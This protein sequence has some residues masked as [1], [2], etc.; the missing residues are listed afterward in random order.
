ML[1][2][3][4]MAV[5]ARAVSAR[6]RSELT[7]RPFAHGSLIVSCLVHGMTR[8]AGHRARAVRRR[9]L[10]AR[11]FQQAVVLAARRAHH[12]VGPERIADE[13]G[14]LREE[15][16]HG[17]R[18]EI[19]IWLNDESRRREIVAGPVR[20][21]ARGGMALRR[22]FREL[23]ERVTLTAH[24][25]RAP[26]IEARGLHDRVI[27]GLP[28]MDAVSAQ[29]IPVRARVRLARTVTR[30]ARDAELGRA[31]VGGKLGDRTR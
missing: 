24:L 18:V 25:R 13:T 31:R 12:A 15:R 8:E 17:R 20:Q 9:V 30:L 6:G 1:R 10:V 7:V 28:E 4:A 5:R 14:V 3:R 16:L 19:A 22:G 11:R 2:S 21:P 27:A 29:R 23:P 26:R